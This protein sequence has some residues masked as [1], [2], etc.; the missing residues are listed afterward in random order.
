MELFVI[1]D[2]VAEVKNSCKHHN[3]GF[4]DASVAAL[5]MEQPNS[6]VYGVMT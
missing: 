2:A 1:S 3:S 4:G 5:Q 6:M